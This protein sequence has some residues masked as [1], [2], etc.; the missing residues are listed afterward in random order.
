MKCI[1]KVSTVLV[2][3]IVS[4]AIIAQLA[5]LSAC[6]S[7]IVSL[8]QNLSISEAQSEGEEKSLTSQAHSS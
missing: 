6:T 3:N 1:N 2:A 5:L 4:T 7:S 8:C